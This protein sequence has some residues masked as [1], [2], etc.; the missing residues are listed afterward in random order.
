MVPTAKRFDISIGKH[1]AQLKQEMNENT[2]STPNQ[3]VSGT[4]AE[5]HT[6]NMVTPLPDIPENTCSLDAP[7]LEKNIDLFLH[8]YMG[9]AQ[10]EICEQ[11]TRHL[12]NCFHCFEIFTQVLTDYYREYDVKKHKET[13]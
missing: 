13:D 4:S 7:F 3:P 5:E 2:A 6:N 11:L 1:L 9:K 10:P 8:L 12:N